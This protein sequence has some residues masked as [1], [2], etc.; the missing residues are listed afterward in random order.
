MCTC[1]RYLNTLSQKIIN[2]NNIME[3]LLLSTAH[4]THFPPNTF[5]R[6][7]VGN[8]HRPFRLA[9]SWSNVVM[10]LTTAF[11]KAAFFSC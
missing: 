10:S 9:K 6:K 8:V 1:Y 7:M 5:R 4:T 11:L 3:L 2:Y